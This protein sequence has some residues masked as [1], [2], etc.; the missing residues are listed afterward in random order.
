MVS[1]KIV[2]PH[3]LRLRDSAD[4]IFEVESGLENSF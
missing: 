1:R 4:A 3:G 2:N